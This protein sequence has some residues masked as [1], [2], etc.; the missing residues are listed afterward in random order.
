MF[1]L[2][3]LCMFMYGY[4]YVSLLITC[5]FNL[6]SKKLSI[7]CIWEVQAC[8]NTVWVRIN[9]TVSFLAFLSIKYKDFFTNKLFLLKYL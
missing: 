3:I 5:L 6:H 8:M 4:T 9:E 7:E 1:L 2:L